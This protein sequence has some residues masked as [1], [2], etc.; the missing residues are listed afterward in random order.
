MWRDR[1]RPECRSPPHTRPARQ[2][3][4]RQARQQRA[5]GLELFSTRQ[6][7][8]CAP[9]VGTDRTTEQSPAA[10][11]TNDADDTRI[12][13]DQLPP[14]GQPSTANPRRIR[15]NAPQVVAVGQR[16]STGTPWQ[17]RDPRVP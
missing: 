3:S 17:E 13:R 7:A 10:L 1:G 9:P 16:D 11:E 2:L 12:G 8:Q 5:A 6:D 15:Y 4:W 14:L